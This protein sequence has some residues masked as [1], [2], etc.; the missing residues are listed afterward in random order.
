MSIG[1]N[2]FLLNSGERYCIIINKENGIPLYYPNLY[3]TTQFRNRG[4]S[5]STIESIAVDIA[6][7]YRFLK[8]SEISIEDS[9]LQRKYLSNSDIERLAIFMSKKFSLK[10]TRIGN[11][12]TVSKQTLY[13]RLNNI[14]LYLQWLSNIITECDDAEDKGSFM[15]MIIAIKERRPRYDKSHIGKDY[16]SEAL[17]EAAINMIMELV[18]PFSDINPFEKYVRKRNEIMII[19]LHELGIRCGELLSIKIEDID[20]KKYT[21]RIKRRADERSD[22]RVKQPLVKTLGRTLALSEYL[23]SKIYQYIINDR[24][25]IIKKEN[26]YLLVT[27]KAGHQQG[28]PLSVSAYHKMIYQLAVSNPLLKNLKGHQFRHNWNYEF[29]KLMDSQPQTISENEKKGIQ[30]NVMGWGPNSKT[31]AIYNKRF[32]IEKTNEASMRLQERLSVSRKGKEQYDIK[33]KK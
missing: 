8:C 13:T 16:E 30:N 18:D 1:T 23:V 27:H 33:C 17:S 31:G 2:A 20:F 5:I 21:L 3:L 7:F 28:E 25:K 15:N 26:G 29:S 9:V 32:I 4:Y 14:S 11:T 10:R 19:M 6:L 12:K 24:R 22:T